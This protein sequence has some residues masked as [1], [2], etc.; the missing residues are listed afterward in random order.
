MNMAKKEIIIG[1]CAVL[2]LCVLFF[3]ID[4]LKGV[5]V[6]K[7]TNFYS[8]SYTNV[9]GLQV[10]APVSVNGFKVGQVRTIAYEYD[11]PGHVKV[12]F[13]LDKALRVPEGS[14]AVIETSILGTSEVVL[15]LSDQ[16]ELLPM[17]SQIIGETA[18][19]MMQDVS[20][21]IMPSAV[22]VIAKIDT[23]LATVNAL[24]ANPAI[25]QSVTRLDAITLNMEQTMRAI[26]KTTK[27]LP[28]VLDNVDSITANLA[29]MT[30]TLGEVTQTL[31]E[32]PLDPTMQNILA[33]TENLKTFT[34]D[35]NNPNSSLGAMTHSKELY[36]NLNATVASLNALL[37][38]VKANPK[39]YI[40]I[41]LL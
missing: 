33:L 19:G 8:A 24:L 40:S 17:G 29:A 20:E 14:K 35:L 37:Q 1:L 6:L 13:S 2:A 36:D 10:S 27:R 34:A 16:K 26:N 15:K 18:T 31:K 30:A 21:K 39:R 9:S 41:K 28:P 38:D 25:S 11:N 3:G 5:N 12:E 22:G 4:Y 32:L 7:P 23:L